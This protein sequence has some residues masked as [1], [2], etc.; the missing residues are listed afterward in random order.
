MGG[1]VA[2]EEGEGHQHT[3]FTFIGWCIAESARWL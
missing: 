1:W 3:L 2:A